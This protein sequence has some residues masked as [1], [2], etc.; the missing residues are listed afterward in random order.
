VQRADV[1]AYLPGD[2]AL[3]PGPILPSA[4][5]G[6]A[7]L[8][9]RGLWVHTAP[10]ASAIPLT[11]AGAPLVDHAS[12]TPRLPARLGTIPVYVDPASRWTVAEVARVRSAL[13]SINRATPGLSLVEAP[14]GLGAMIVLR[15]G[16]MSALWLATAVGSTDAGQVG[17][18]AAVVLV[19]NAV[20]WWAGVGAGGIGRDEYDLETAVL[21]ELCHVLG[22]NHSDDLNSPMAET[23]EEGVTRRALTL[24]EITAL[25]GLYPPSHR[26]AAAVDALDAV[27][28]ASLGD[29]RPRHGWDVR[30]LRGLAAIFGRARRRTIGY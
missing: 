18:E 24:A 16:E 23:L 3:V 12:G 17:G 13:A 6:L 2:T 21:H 8:D 9:V 10:A 27:F 14:S 4:Q 22:L 19:S 7:A 25:E 30:G 20:S 1:L 11:A 29:L 26:A 15:R 28:S 5:F